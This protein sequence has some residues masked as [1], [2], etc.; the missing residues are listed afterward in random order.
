MSIYSLY[1]ILFTLYCIIFSY[2]TPFLF[3]RFLCGR[4]KK[5][6]LNLQA[7]CDHQRRFI[8]ID[9][10]F[11]GSSSDFLCFV[12]SF[13]SKKLHEDGVVV[14]GLC[15]YGD[16]AYAN[17]MKMA[18]PFKGAQAG[19]KDAYNF[20]HSQLRINI[21]CAFGM[22]VHRWGVLRKPIPVNISI[23]KT[24]HLV[25]ALCMLHNFCINER[26][27]SIPPPTHS[28]VATIANE[29]GDTTVT[30]RTPTRT[31]VGGGHHSDDVGGRWRQ[32]NV[33]NTNAQLPR[34]VLI[35][36]LIRIRRTRRPKPMGSTSTNN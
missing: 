15:L 30:R 17:N 13:I 12:N 11:P 19:P 2:P 36:F 10:G 18:V 35:S 14:D 8:A 7:V 29:S 27:S 32:H 20:Y 9:I 34:N 6:G 4:K 33:N 24:T 25:R 21:E 16:A 23:D 5:F 3:V 26:E 28:D 1:T 22:L 31:L